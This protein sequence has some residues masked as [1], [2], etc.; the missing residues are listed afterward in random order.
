MDE[1][2]DESIVRMTKTGRRNG[3][4]PS[5]NHPPKRN[6]SAKPGILIMF[7]LRVFFLV[8]GLALSNSA[9]AQADDVTSSFK[10][11][12]PEEDARFR[13]LLAEPVPQG[14]STQALLEHF[15]VKRNAAER[16]GDVTLRKALMLQWVDSM[17]NEILPKHELATLLGNE[18]NFE[19]ALKLRR[20]LVDSVS[21]EISKEWYRQALAYLYYDFGNY[22]KA[23]VELDLVKSAIP[24]LKIKFTKP[25]DAFFVLRV[26]SS[27]LLTESLI[28]RDFGR[29]DAAINSA[30]KAV[31]L[32]RQTLQ[33]V[34][35]LP[36]NG[37]AGSQARL[38][39]VV[40]DLGNSLAKKEGA[41]RQA[42]RFSEAEDTLKEYIKFSQQEELPP[43]F[44]FGLNQIAGRLKFDQQEFSS[45]E[46]YYRR[47]DVALKNLGYSEFSLNRISAAKDIISSLNGQQ[48]SDESIKIIDGLDS[49]D[50]NNRDSKNRI[51]MP[52]DRGI[53]YLLSNTRI[54]EAVELFTEYLGDLRKRYPE[55]HFYVAQ[56]KGVLGVALWNLGQSESKENALR[57]LKEAAH[58]Y[59]LADNVEYE[60]IGLR[61]LVRDLVFAKYLEATFELKLDTTGAMVP[62]D[63]VRGGRVQEALAD[64]AVRSAASDPAL[65]ALVRGDQDSKNEM[66]ALRNFLTGEAGS[67]KTPLPE[68]AAKMR[69]RMNELEIVRRQSQVEIRAKFPDYDKLVR[70][71]PPTT[72]DIQ[73]TLAPDEALLTLLP[74]DDAVYVWA[75]TKDGKNSAVRVAIAKP[76]L[77]RLISGMRKTL[78]FAEMANYLR[79]FDTVAS[80]ELY[81]KLLKPVETSFKDKKHLIVAAGGPLG[82]IPFGVLLTQQ[83]TKVDANAPW[84]IKQAAITHI[85]SLSA[86]LAVKQFAKAKSAPESLDA[87]GDP[88]FSNKVQVATNKAPAGTATRQVVFT[89]AAAAVDLEKEDPRSAIKYSDIPA[90]PETRDELLAIANILQADNSHDLRLGSQASKASV[91]ESSKT[92]ELQKKKVVVFATHGLMAGDLPHLTQPALALASTGNEDTDPLGALLTLDEVLNLKLNADWVILSACNTAAADGKADEAL[93]GLARGFFYAGSRSLLVTHWAVES[94]SAK[95]LTTNTMKNYMANPTQR[96]AESLRQAMLTVMA[97]PQFQHPAYWAPYALVGDGGR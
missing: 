65:A 94:A 45:A 27:A 35:N 19:Q 79:N 52:Y 46:Q 60:G 7:I 15:R 18:G 39:V 4:C 73:Q 89:R 53:S 16:L 5:H 83:V 38:R 67:T 26:E 70:P 34:R 28:H 72:A 23:K 6:I 66:E 36:N 95:E 86:W 44:K 92:G 57:L 88:Q 11:I 85:P 51:R 33:L 13:A 31:T 54:K 69:A 71:A 87:W 59:M 14:L 17:P 62:A 29:W 43:D 63:W 90:L 10:T 84:L 47:A 82:Q 76:E 25:I 24:K 64:A 58:D 20:E 75:V 97:K 80:S 56:A 49:L 61:S 40:E 8:I 41:Q 1:S 74:T 30:D 9:F 32:R 48:R 81:R 50:T 37:D 3:C 22:E 93:S 68:V 21:A 42:R 78:D 2:V 55:N 12:S 96:K 91:L 77:I